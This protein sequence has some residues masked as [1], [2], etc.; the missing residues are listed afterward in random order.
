MND[1][2]SAATPGAVLPGLALALA[3]LA[4]VVYDS[5]ALARFYAE[6]IAV[7]RKLA[8]L[9]LQRG[10]HREAL[11]WAREVLFVDLEDAIDKFTE[12]FRGLTA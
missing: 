6:N 4:C 7:R 8:Q 3:G 11:A 5:I 9:A 2:V 10:D 1:Y 12:F